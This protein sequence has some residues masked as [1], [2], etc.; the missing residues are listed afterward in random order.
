MVSFVGLT[1]ALGAAASET[2]QSTM[3][4]ERIGIEDG[5]SQ[6]AVMDVVQDASG[7]LWFATESGVDR[8]DGFQFQ[9]YR[10][11]RGN[12]ASLADNFVRD[13]EVGGDG[14]VWAAT[15]GGGVARWDPESDSFKT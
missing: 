14:S 7:F 2:L 8:Y 11:E 4:F 6:S 1:L 9:H 13:L 10:H 15:A 5:L 3:R 12:P